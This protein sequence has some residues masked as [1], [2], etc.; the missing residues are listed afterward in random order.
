M[1]GVTGVIV[2]VTIVV[3]PTATVAAF[4]ALPLTWRSVASTSTSTAPPEHGG[5]WTAT[6]AR[7]LLLLDH[8]AM[9]GK[10]FRRKLADARLSLLWRQGTEIAA[11]ASMAVI[12]RSKWICCRVTGG[13]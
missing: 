8:A 5:D 2:V 10:L 9:V 7:L 6:E 12:A 13:F 1:V 3:V 4:P 11:A